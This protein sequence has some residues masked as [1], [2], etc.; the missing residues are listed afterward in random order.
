MFMC[1]VRGG[2]FGARRRTGNAVRLF[3]W[4]VCGGAVGARR[5]ARE[6]L[7][8]GWDAGVMPV[9]CGWV[10][11]GM[12]PLEIRRISMRCRW[13]G[14]VARVG[15]GRPSG[16]PGRAGPAGPGRA[17]PWP[18]WRPRLSVGAWGPGRFPIF[19][20]L[21]AVAAA[22]GRVICKYAPKPCRKQVDPKNAEKYVFCK[23][24]RFFYKKISL[25]SKK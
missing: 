10:A 18:G 13:G 25:L 22:W 19:R 9:G 2:A 17:P 14:P 21:C 4:W 1:W 16:R 23:K 5:R 20:G 7:G 12:G 8:C 15:R 6:V 11:V 24:N 3:V